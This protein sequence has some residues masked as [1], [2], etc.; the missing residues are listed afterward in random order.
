MLHAQH[1]ARTKKQN[2][3]RA[4]AEHRKLGALYI[5]I[6]HGQV[7]PVDEHKDNARKHIVPGAA[8]RVGAEHDK[9]AV[10]Q[11]DERDK[12]RAAVHVREEQAKGDAVDV[13]EEKDAQ[14]P[15]QKN[16][17]HDVVGAKGEANG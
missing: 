9:E 5:G 17:A 16:C 8:D 3:Q 10:L 13:E 11:H 12:E 14:R 1:N 4:R 6:R 7:V 2:A 15:H